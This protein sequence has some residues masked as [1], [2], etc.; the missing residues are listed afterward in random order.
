MKGKVVL[1]YAD[2]KSC[3]VEKI[4]RN[5]RKYKTL[6]NR[7]VDGNWHK[8]QLAKPNAKKILQGVY[9]KAKLI[10]VFFSSTY[11]SDYRCRMEWRVIQQKLYA[12][13]MNNQAKLML[14]NLEPFNGKKLGIE[15]SD[16]YIDAEHMKNKKVAQQIF[17]RW[18]CMKQN[19]SLYKTKNNDYTQVI[20]H[21]TDNDHDN[22]SQN[23]DTQI[24]VSA[25]SSVESESNNSS[26]S[27]NEVFLPSINCCYCQIVII[28]FY[29]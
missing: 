28:F 5:L 21:T 26:D 29:F 1:S 7:I 8:P 24:G 3:R 19:S 25:K 20:P 11:H 18:K 6:K 10:V 2:K 17:R 27:L 15:K 14:I 22:A 4:V 9:R 12:G 13:N 16:G 23:D